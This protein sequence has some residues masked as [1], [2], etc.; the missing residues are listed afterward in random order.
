MQWRGF[1]VYLPRRRRAP[2]SERRILAWL[3]AAASRPLSL[4]HRSAAGV[5]SSQV[6][7]GGEAAG[8]WAGAQRDS[9]DRSA[10]PPISPPLHTTATPTTH[11]IEEPYELSIVWWKCAEDGRKGSSEESAL[12]KAEQRHPRI[13]R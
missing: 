2:A 12:R 6:A 5:V 10:R 3:A 9:I 4:V 8:Q 7:S 11:P 13:R 1:D